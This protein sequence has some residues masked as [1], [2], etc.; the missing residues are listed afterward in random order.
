M[1]RVGKSAL[2]GD[3]RGKRCVEDGMKSSVGCREALEKN[4]CGCDPFFQHRCFGRKSVGVRFVFGIAIGLRSNPLSNRCIE[5]SL[6]CLHSGQCVTVVFIHRIERS[7]RQKEVLLWR[8]QD[9]LFLRQCARE[10]DTAC[11]EGLEA[12]FVVGNPQRHADLQQRISLCLQLKIVGMRFGIQS[13]RNVLLRRFPEDGICI[14]AFFV[15]GIQKSSIQYR[16]L[17]VWLRQLPSCF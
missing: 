10:S 13:D 17:F 5:Q 4:C 1:E 9:R 3:K 14:I 15:Y 7:T 6:G 2:I 11:I 12:I 16:A 8:W